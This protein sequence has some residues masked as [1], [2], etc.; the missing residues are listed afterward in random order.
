M[1]QITRVFLCLCGL[2]V[3]PVLVIGEL[4]FKWI[5]KIIFKGE[6]IFSRM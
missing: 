5:G 1:I 2:I 4:I 3:F 6:D